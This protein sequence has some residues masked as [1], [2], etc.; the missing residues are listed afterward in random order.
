MDP[1]LMNELLDELEHRTCV[2][3]HSDTEMREFIALVKELSAPAVFP[4]C[5]HMEAWDWHV[6]RR[7]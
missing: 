3:F 2:R 4:T 6:F 1:A 7:R 5:W